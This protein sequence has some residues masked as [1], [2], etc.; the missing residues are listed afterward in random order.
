MDLVLLIQG[1]IISNG[2]GYDGSSNSFDCKQTIISNINSFRINH[3]K[4]VL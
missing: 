1:P 3:H 4:V 2:M